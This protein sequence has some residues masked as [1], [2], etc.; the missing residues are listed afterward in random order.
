MVA[1]G[2]GLKGFHRQSI[3][4]AVGAVN[5]I[6]LSRPIADEEPLQ[7]G[8][9]DALIREIMIAQRGGAA[10]LLFA[11]FVV[12]LLVRDAT[13]RVIP[14][15]FVT[16]ISV[17]LLRLVGTTWLLRGAIDR[18]PRMHL[19][20]ASAVI[21]LLTGGSLAGI[22]LLAGLHTPV[23]TTL[24]LLMVMIGIAS[25]AMVSLAGSPFLYVTY[26]G[27]LMSACFVLASVRP[28]PALEQVF[29]VALPVYT[30][31]LAITM[32]SIPRALRGKIILGLKL[33]LSFDELRD[34]QARLVEASRQAG[35]SDV[36]TAVLHNVG[37]VL[38][39]VNVSA[40]VVN[41]IIGSLRTEP[42][43]K[44]AAM[45]TDNHGDLARF[46]RD[47]Q[48]GQKLPAYFQQVQAA[49]E[50]DKTAAASELQSLI[51]NIDHIKVIV[52]SQNSHVV[53]GG[54]TE[55]FDIRD[56]LDDALKF[57]AA[58]GAPGAIEYLR[59][60]DAVPTVRLDRHKVLQIVMNL[61]K[62]ACDAVRD[63]PAGE[64][65]IAVS[66]RGIADA[67]LEIA[68]ADSGCGIAADDADRIFNLGFTTKPDGNGLG[69]H[70]S[71]CA[72]RE[73]EGSL[74]AH[75]PGTGQGA[76]FVLVLPLD[77]RAAA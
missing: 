32:R 37:N 12:W 14:A 39:S 77:A 10:A 66:L 48:R 46:F 61:L 2:C 4:T 15:L 35:R 57:S 40:A 43:S 26:I 73:L 41:G 25:T 60:F 71:A 63:K 3:R 1:P 30:L 70:Y 44:V 50:R 5:L 8:L 51:R 11:S 76:T 29:P 52:S 28:L 74:S 6:T 58:S 13:S 55:T 56:L 20:W 42:L 45:I 62:N 17:T 7:A 9:N 47:D 67:R 33:G 69:L 21:Y 64:R 65:R 54:A 72:A 24:M 59:R 53:A 38:N 68:I 18:L 34:A 31:V 75:S 16:L 49:L 22:V 27:P 23:P 36:A 19:F